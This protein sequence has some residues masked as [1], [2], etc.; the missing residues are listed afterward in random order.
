MPIDWRIQVDGKDLPGWDEEKD[1]CSFPDFEHQEFLFPY[2]DV[3]DQLLD[4]YD[5]TV[6]AASPACGR[7]RTARKARTQRCTWIDTR[8]RPWPRKPTR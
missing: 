1:G 2:F 3:G 7:S 5:Q 4:P 8:S 6:F